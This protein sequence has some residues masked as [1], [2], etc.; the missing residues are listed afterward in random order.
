MTLKI[1]TLGALVAMSYSTFAA[2]PQTPSL[3]IIDGTISVAEDWPYMT[4]L[5]NKGVSAYYGQFCGGSYIGGNY[6]LTAAHCLDGKGPD[7]LD[8]VVGI[9]QLSQ[10]GSQGARISVEHIYIH[11][12]YDPNNWVNDIAILSLSREPASSEASAVDYADALT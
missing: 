10:E 12:D 6:I 2:E 1:M 8:V 4:A 11:P 9:H 5:V 7:D 3:R